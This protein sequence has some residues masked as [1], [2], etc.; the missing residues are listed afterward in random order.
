MMKTGL[1][2]HQQL[3]FLTL[4]PKCAYQI[5]LDTLGLGLFRL[6]RYMVLQKRL[7]LTSSAD[8]K[9]VLS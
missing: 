8:K 3:S 5:S 1:S 2:L 9:S 7:P 4:C 6:L